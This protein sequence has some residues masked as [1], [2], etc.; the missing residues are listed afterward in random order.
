MTPD[1]PLSLTS[2]ETPYE[3]PRLEQALNESDLRRQF[4]FFSGHGAGDHDLGSC[5]PASYASQEFQRQKHLGFPVLI[6]G[7]TVTPLSE[8]LENT[9]HGSALERQTSY[10]FYLIVKILKK[11]PLID[12][13]TLLNECRQAFIDEAD[14][15]PQAQE[16]VAAELAQRCLDEELKGTVL[17]LSPDALQRLYELALKAAKQHE[18]QAFLQQIRSLV[19][20]LENRLKVH[21]DTTASSL[22]A[23]EMGSLADRFIKPDNLSDK[24]RAR[25]RGSKPLSADRLKRMEDSLDVLR[26]FLDL[27]H[28]E[29]VP[30][31]WIRVHPSD[32]GS[33]LTEMTHATTTLQKQ[34]DLMVDVFRALRIANLELRGQYDTDLHDEPFTRFD[35]QSLSPGERRILPALVINLDYAWLEH[36]QHALEAL[37]AQQIPIHVVAE[38]TVLATGERH[39][40]Q[41][42]LAIA[43]REAFILES[44][45]ARPVH[46]FEGLQAL[47]LSGRPGL[48][49][50]SQ[51][52]WNQGVDQDLQLATALMTRDTVLLRFDP[53][54]GITFSRCL[55]VDGNEQSRQL[56][57]LTHLDLAEGQLPCAMTFADLAAIQPEFHD[58]FWPLSADAWGDHQI[59]IDQYLEQ[60]EIGNPNKIPFIWCI[61]ERQIRRCLV[62]QRIVHAASRR[63]HYWRTIQELAGLDNEF[64]H[65]AAE[66]ARQQAESS[67]QIKIESVEG[68]MHEAIDD[69][70]REATR[71][72][73]RRLSYALLGLELESQAPLKAVEKPSAPPSE[74]PPVERANRDSLPE[75]QAPPVETAAEVSDIEDPYIDSD[76][77]TSCN[78]CINLNS[79]LFRYNA[80][81]QAEIAAVESGTFAQLVLAASK[82]PARCIHPG[83]PRPGDT[84]ATPEMIAQA[85][86]YQ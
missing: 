57:T 17:G 65:A 12:S 20:A 11:T 81:K 36:Q 66:R 13:E 28:T 1:A 85:E 21:S 54:R 62:S 25:K 80:D 35:H 84:S 23:N 38:Q 40:S 24:L 30:L 73:M 18:W 29:R 50:V 14:L 4:R 16:E 53:N 78:E 6:H 47:H 82:C 52:S 8:R 34:V 15:S 59:P 22:D 2:S 5:L 32:S 49:V 60:I 41:A 42:Y 44:S 37:I 58:Q 27:P 56:H 76:L 79:L 31:H 69:A 61:Q 26:A 68:S 70:R 83:T 55:N 43:H 9:L 45:L 77:C 71:T 46:L 48:V 67:A 86:Q 64:A 75:V 7:T 33:A 74:T 39:T 72:A 51:P 3:L 63:R 10:L 19:H